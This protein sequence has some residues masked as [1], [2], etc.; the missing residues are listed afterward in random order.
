MKCKNPKCDNEA[1]GRAKT[2]SSKCRVALH[3]TVTNGSVTSESVTGTITD[4]VG[5]VHP[6]DYEVRRKNHATLLA[7][8]QGKGTIAQQVLGQLSFAYNGE[9]NMNR[10]LGLE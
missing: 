5:K 8:A 9:I 1:K 10:Y 3:R 2:C 7:W 6:V 4:A